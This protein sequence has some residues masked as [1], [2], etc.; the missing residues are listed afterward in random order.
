MS[1]KKAETARLN[2]AK[3]RGPVTAEGK[4]RSSKN[5]ITHGLHS[6]LVVLRHESCAAFERLR[7]SYMDDFQP[8]TQ[9]ESDLVETMAVAR[10]RLNRLFMTEPFMFQQKMETAEHLFRDLRAP[11]RG[12]EE[13]LARI[14]DSPQLNYSLALMMR[15]EGQL[16]RT[17]EKAFK[18]LQALKKE[19][20]SQPEPELRNEPTEP[21][22]SPSVWHPCDIRGPEISVPTPSTRPEPAQNPEQPAM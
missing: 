3:S 4:A 15:Y 9:S 14:F 16:N 18:H 8:A 21:A 17:Y 10:W 6:D 20:Q 22:S 1:T 5:A 11:G 12:P 2:G 19:R 7:E 13:K